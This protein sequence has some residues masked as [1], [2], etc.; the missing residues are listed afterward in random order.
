M[1]PPKEPKTFKYPC[2]YYQ[3]GM[4]ADAWA[5]SGPRIRIIYPNGKVEWACCNKL[6][7]SSFHPMMKHTFSS[8][9]CY[10]DNIKAH[11]GERTLA[12]M[13][14]FD[15]QNSFPPAEYLGEIR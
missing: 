8:R 12:L 9:A 7:D 11:S 5:L 2:M 4:R 3:P 13:R 14:Q 1:K 6:K 15:R 10:M